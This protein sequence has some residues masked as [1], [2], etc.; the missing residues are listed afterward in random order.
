[1]HLHTIACRHANKRG[2]STA[3]HQRG[4]V[5]PLSCLQ[6]SAAQ[7]RRARRGPAQG[8][9]TPAK[10]IIRHPISRPACSPRLS[11]C[12]H[13]AAPRGC[14]PVHRTPTHVMLVDRAGWLPTN[15]VL[16]LESAHPQPRQPTACPVPS[17]RAVLRWV[18]TRSRTGPAPRSGT[19]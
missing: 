15:Q 17:A 12:P 16:L 6:D 10:L 7:R 2:L 9:S 3:R 13:H 5:P 8:G 4:L 11:T 14:L 19:S 18:L 1:M